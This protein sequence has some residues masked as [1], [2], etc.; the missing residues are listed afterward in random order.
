MFQCCRV[1][2]IDHGIDGQ[3]NSD[4]DDLGEF[5]VSHSMH[6]KG[7]L[8]LISKIVGRLSE[9]EPSNAFWLPRS[10]HYDLRR[11]QHFF[12]STR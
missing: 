10:P 9:F 7:F 12:K 5:V 3:Q 4:V 1:N 11:L 6:H 2:E 8:P